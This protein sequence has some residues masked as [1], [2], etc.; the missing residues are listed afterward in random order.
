[1]VGVASWVNEVEVGEEDVDEGRREW[2]LRGEA[3]VDGA[4]ARSGLLDEF[5]HDGTSGSWRVEAVSGC[6]WLV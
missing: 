5:R 6:I 3:V 2:M 4:M 1:M